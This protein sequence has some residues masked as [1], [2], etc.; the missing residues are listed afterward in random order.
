[1]PQPAFK[2]RN[3]LRFFG[4]SF[5]PF[6]SEGRIA[7]AGA[8]LNLICI[9]RAIIQAPEVIML[10]YRFDFGQ[11]GIKTRIKLEFTIQLQCFKQEISVLLEP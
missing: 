2:Q 9:S 8:C 10:T 1:M 6:F 4:R 3:P 11:S 5:V 7:G